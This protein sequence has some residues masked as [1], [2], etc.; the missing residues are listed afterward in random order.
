MEILMVTVVMFGTEPCK[1]QRNELSVAPGLFWCSF[2]STDSLHKSAFANL[3]I[4]NI[5]VL[6]VS[7]TALSFLVLSVMEKLLSSE[8]VSVLHQLL[9]KSA[10][11]SSIIS[12]AA[13][14][15]INTAGI[16]STTSGIA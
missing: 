13:R 11:K 12:Q 15:N 6:L 16:A 5:N 10:H 4:P 9:E 1:C 14:Q 3:T 8:S 2:P 7:P